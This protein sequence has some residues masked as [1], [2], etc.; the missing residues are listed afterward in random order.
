MKGTTYNHLSIAFFVLVSV[1]A[2]HGNAK[3][4]E[5]YQFEADD[6]VTFIE[7]FCK[8]DDKQ[9]K[10]DT[11]ELSLPL[12]DSKFGEKFPGQPPIADWESAK[13]SPDP[14]STR[15]L[16][17]RKYPL[18]LFCPEGPGNLS[19]C[20]GECAKLARGLFVNCDYKV[21]ECK[22]KPVPEGCL[23]FGS[24]EFFNCKSI[25][26]TIGDTLDPI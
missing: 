17:A 6:G 26:E 11:F 3:E 24:C 23:T 13:E 16:A 2:A 22:Q 21:T 14:G 5:S 25:F 10:Y 4:C 18:S 19:I 20:R 15:N 12:K 8:S 9:D 7:R 1:F